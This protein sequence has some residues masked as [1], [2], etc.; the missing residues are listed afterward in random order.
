MGIT[1]IDKRTGESVTYYGSVV[2]NGDTVTIDTAYGKHHY[3]LTRHDVHESEPASTTTL[4]SQER[5][6]WLE[7][8]GTLVRPALWLAVV[9]FVIFAFKYP[10][11]AGGLVRLAFRFVGQTIDLVFWIVA[12]VFRLLF[13][14]LSS[15]VEI[16]V[17]LF[18]F[19]AWAVS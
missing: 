4:E 17:A 15:L 9:A 16:F 2:R 18:R 13:A 19:L 14:L 12:G 7:L 5:P 11:E 1:V 10:T 8:L 6:F 3:S